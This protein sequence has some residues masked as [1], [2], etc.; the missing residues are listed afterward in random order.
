VTTADQGD[1]ATLTLTVAPA[2]GTTTAV[3]AVLSPTGITTSPSTTPSVDR[4]TW[5]AQLPLIEAGEYIAT[6]TVT[7]VGAGVEQQ[8]VMAAPRQ[9]IDDGQL[10]YATTADLAHYL[11]AAPP[12]DARRKLRRA[13]RRVA[14]Y[15][16]LAVYAADD[17]TGMPTDAT[18]IA[19]VRDATCAQVEWWMETGDETGAGAQYQQVSIG[20]L[21]L[22]RG[23]SSA[24][25]ATGPSQTLSAEAIEHLQRA[26]LLSPDVYS[27][28]Y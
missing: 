19:A 21:S 1:I 14:N 8:S 15:I 4:A 20:S 13:S 27:A 7:G 23:Y 11:E 17:V 24:G 22:G 10:V 28:G 12:A 25:S 9:P 3:L 16:R 6:W 26:G 18:I 5:T 2:D